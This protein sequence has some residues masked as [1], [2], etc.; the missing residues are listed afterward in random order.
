M[1]VHHKCIELGSGVFEKPNALGDFLVGNPDS[2]VIVVVPSS[3]DIRFVENIL[4]RRALPAR[5]ISR[6]LDEGDT[7]QVITWLETQKKMILVCN[8]SVAQKIS[9]YWSTLIILYA[10]LVDTET[11]HTLSCPSSDTLLQNRT[12]LSL[13]SPQ[14]LTQFLPIKKSVTNCESIS[15]DPLN[16]SVKQKNI[17]DNALRNLPARGSSLATELTNMYSAELGLNIS[18]AD[19]ESFVTLK[20]L[21]TFFMEQHLGSTPPLSIEEELQPVDDYAGEQSGD[22]PNNKGSRNSEGETSRNDKRGDSHRGN[23]QE[24]SDSDRSQKGSGRSSNKYTNDNKSKKGNFNDVQ[25]RD[26]RYSSRNTGR[27]EYDSRDTGGRDRN[28]S[29]RGGSRNRNIPKYFPIRVYV[30]LGEDQSLKPHEI[31]DFLA[32]NAQID[33]DHVGFANVRNRYSFVDLTEEVADKVLNKESGYEFEGRLV[34]VERALTAVRPRG[35]STGG[36]SSG[37]RHSGNFTSA[38]TDSTY[39]NR[40]DDETTHSADSGYSDDD[41]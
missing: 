40:T 38:N 36:R 9:T 22:Y 35:H 18:G 3:S 31:K 11:Y 10:P 26:H 15:L 41:I 5:R 28:N 39:D 7:R 8:P 4:R 13:L 20:K 19:S 17:L 34:T 16:T 12:M 27:N 2:D 14:E 25:R 6:A 23:R 37:K 21:I 29:N 1:E 32:E 30:G 33:R 24:N